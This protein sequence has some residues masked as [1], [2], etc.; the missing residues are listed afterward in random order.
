MVVLNCTVAGCE[1]ATVDV[2]A[3]AAAALLTNH[4]T[5]HIA[6]ANAGNNNRIR[7]QKVNRPEIKHGSDNESW[8]YFL[9]R[10]GQYKAS[11]PGLN[12]QSLNLQLLECCGEELR[13]DI[14][15]AEGSVDN[16]TEAEITAIIKRLAVKTE[17][18]MVARVKLHNM[19]QDPGEEA[20]HFASRLLGQAKT[21][22]FTI[23]CGNA[24]CA[25]TSYLDN[26]VRDQLIKGLYDM[27]VREQIL[28]E[29]DQNMSLKD[30]L[31]YIEAKEAG[32]RSQES[33]STPSVASRLSTDYQRQKAKLL[34]ANKD[35]KIAEGHNDD[36]PPEDNLD[37]P[38][39]RFH[40][41]CR[42]CG[43]RH[44]GTQAVSS[45]KENC[46]A[47]GEKCSS[48]DRSHHLS[49]VCEQRNKPSSETEDETDADA[50][51]WSSF[52]VTN[53]DEQRPHRQVHK[54]KHP[55]RK[56]GG[57][58][59]QGR[60]KEKGEELDMM[61]AQEVLREHARLETLRMSQA[62]EISLRDKTSFKEESRRVENQT[63][64]TV[65]S[66]FL[67]DGIENTN[68]REDYS[69]TDCSSSESGSVPPEF[70]ENHTERRTSTKRLDS[71]QHSMT[72]YSDSESE[73][74]SPDFQHNH[75]EYK[76][77]TMRPEPQDQGPWP[78]RRERCRSD[79]S[80][81]GL[82]PDYNNGMT[83]SH[84]ASLTEGCSNQ[85]P[86]QNHIQ[87]HH[88]PPHHPH[89]TGMTYS[90]PITYD[91]IARVTEQNSDMRALRSMVVTGF[92]ES[93]NEMPASI[94]SFYPH[95]AL[96][97]VS[98]SF[99]LYGGSIVIPVSLTDD[100]LGPLNTASQG[101]LSQSC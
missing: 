47:Y 98:G 88:S 63:S 34:R 26:M 23:Q 8:S 21:C 39:V 28:G 86:Y 66:Q 87:T 76:T 71:E 29:K 44:P 17:N 64:S 9:E 27:D 48:C 1:F 33:L 85:L 54:A 99:L 73:S 19:S 31:A 45:R 91:L 83:R 50:A 101:E 25:V 96:L 60:R 36:D 100:L 68:Y 57:K 82:H 69:M 97:Q 49:R 7:P 11:C 46:P 30:T 12:A 81:T 37:K 42:F 22:N 5:T 80:A 53:E 3:V 14:F 65:Q 90:L 77:S 24:A 40:K 13:Q 41:K 95:R 32:K 79:Q 10:W 52:S 62:H 35:P 16:K 75:M 74:V 67:L 38:K 72:E 51:F 58:R 89:G 15:R 93:E 94:R 92:P 4:N 59:R 20:Q 84:S 70:Q 18:T 2:E 43:A 78:S 61:H 55:R 6:N 56:R